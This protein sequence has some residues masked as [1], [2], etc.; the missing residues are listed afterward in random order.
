M[1]KHIKF[2]GPTS[3]LS[4]EIFC[5]PD[6][7]IK[8]ISKFPIKNKS[9]IYS[10]S[11]LRSERSKAKSVKSTFLEKQQHARIQILFPFDVQETQGREN[12]IKS[13]AAEG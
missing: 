11:K 12:I 7:L 13:S 4:F 8:H 3:V 1:A 9:T 5:I 6:T 10:F 2:C